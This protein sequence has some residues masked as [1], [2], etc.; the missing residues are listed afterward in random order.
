MKKLL[1]IAILATSALSFSQFSTGFE[2]ST[3]TASSPLSGVVDGTFTWVTAEGGSAYTTQ[4]AIKHNG[5]QA[6]TF[7]TG[8]SFG[9]NWAWV[10]LTQ[11]GTNSTYV[12]SVYVYC[13]TDTA[14]TLFS[15]FGMDVY[16][17]DNMATSTNY[18]RIAFAT[19]SADLSTTLGSATSNTG[20]ITSTNDA[21][22]KLTLVMNLNSKVA[23]ASLDNND[24]G[25]SVAIDPLKTSISDVDL[26]SVA[27]GYNVGYFDDMKIAEYTTNQQTIA[28]RVMLN[29]WLKSPSV[30]PVTVSLLD[31]S[32][33]VI[34]SHNTTCD[35][36]GYFTVAMASS[37]TYAVSVKSTHWLAKNAGSVTLS[38]TSAYTPVGTVSLTNGDVDGDNVVSVFDYIRISDSFDKVLGDGGYD[39]EADLDGDDVVSIFDYIILS[40]HFDEPGFGA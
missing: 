7:D 28:G 26:Y 16:G 17:Y 23:K 40:D 35:S 34:E 11:A 37:G 1:T 15:R 2:P 18:G 12:A 19:I 22:H 6:E 10:D 20:T 4:T 30:Y 38:G 13:A 27:S 9:G 39:A 21:W 36:E 31:G 32:N 5:A 3:Y 24:F 25:V 8:P 33:N 14:H 29:D